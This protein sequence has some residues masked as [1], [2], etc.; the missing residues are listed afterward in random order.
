MARLKVVYWC[1]I[2]SPYIVERLNAVAARG[3]VDLE[4]W[5]NA[6]TRSFRQWEVDETQWR[7]EY[8]YLHT[9]RLFSHDVGWAPL[10]GGANSPDVLFTLYSDPVFVLG[11]LFARMRGLRIMY[12]VEQ[13]PRV[14]YPPKWWKEALKNFLFKRVDGLAYIG[15]ET[16][17]YAMQYSR[18][19]QRFAY[20]PHVID[21]RHFSKALDVTPAQRQELRAKYGLKGV[22]FMYAGRFLEWK[23]LDCLLESF[24][25][26]QRKMT[27][28]ISL[29]LV[30]G[31]EGEGRLREAVAAKG[32]RNVVFTG[33]IQKRDMPRHYAAGDVFVFP[34]FGDTYGLVVDEAMAAGIPVIC[35]EAAGEIRERIEDGTS[36][37]IVPRKDPRALSAGM[38]KLALSPDLRRNMRDKALAWIENR[39]PDWWAGLFERAVGSVAGDSSSGE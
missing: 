1:T 10:L 19:S 17:K 30:G 7:F 3:K 35:S 14:L 32:I 26:L 21:V 20:L 34:T 24:S 27:E 38:E 22:A 23:G 5:F 18:E 12:L 28:E 33:F 15:E 9:F 37:M 2:P 31:G 29:M 8:R 13:T 11:W 4:V 16:K 39:T 6:R 36:G 25:G